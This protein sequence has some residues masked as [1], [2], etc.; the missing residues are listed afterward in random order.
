[1][2]ELLAQTDWLA[3]RD[4]HQ[5]RVDTLLGRYLQRRAQGHSHPVIDFLFTYYN[6]R[7]AQLRRW[8]PGLRVTLTG[9]A[10]EDYAVL[11]GYRHTELGVSVD[12]AY[13]ARKR[14]TAEYVVRLLAATAERPA[15]LGCFGLHEWAMVYRST[16]IR[17]S[18]PLRLGR[19]GTDHVVESMPLR[20]THYDAF[21]FFSTAARPRNSATLTRAG[22]LTAEQPGCLHAGMDLY[23]FAAKLV[24]LIDSD[25]LWQAFT[26]AYD[27]RELDMRA[28]PYELAEYGYTPVPIETPAGR[29]EYVRQQSALAERA[30][31]VRSA[32]LA[33]CESF[34]G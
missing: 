15:Q 17:H 4:S 24:P 31:T 25:L 1:V 16:D 13:L 30:V 28:S 33:R 21:R 12:P 6:L 34:A 11:R 2:S 27:A 20:C 3:R 10:A 22:Q 18:A 26:L 8:H 29:A 14:D 5:H 19:D 7:P 32:L 9:P 23:R